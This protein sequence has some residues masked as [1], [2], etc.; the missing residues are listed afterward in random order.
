MAKIRERKTRDVD[1]VKSIKD[2]VG[3]LL[4]KDGEIKH[5]WRKYFNKLFNGET[6][7]ST[8]E[9]DDSLDDTSRHFMR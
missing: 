8:I 9:L 1:Q 7:S 4:V 2:G 6:G 3:Q 5:R